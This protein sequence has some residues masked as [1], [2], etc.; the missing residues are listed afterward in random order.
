MGP[1]KLKA[2]LLDK[3]Y[4]VVQSAEVREDPF[5]DLD[6]QFEEEYNDPE[7]IDLMEQILGNNHCSY[8]ACV[9]DDDNKLTCFDMDNEHDKRTFLSE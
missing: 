3:D 5:H 4:N 1:G 6:I 8:D 9:F 2:G 7:I